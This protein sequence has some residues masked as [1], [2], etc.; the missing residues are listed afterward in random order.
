MGTPERF[1]VD[2]NHVESIA[3]E[4]QA[5]YPFQECFLE[6]FGVNHAK[7]STDGIVGGNAVSELDKLLEPGEPDL[8]EQFDVFPSVSATEHGKNGQNK[9]ILEVMSLGSIHSGFFD[10]RHALHQTQL[11]NHSMDSSKRKGSVSDIFRC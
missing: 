10:R 7:D 11:C 4:L 3:S 2:G 5:G 8:G 9:D 6:C 1:T